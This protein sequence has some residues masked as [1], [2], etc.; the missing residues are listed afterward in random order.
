[1]W[2]NHCVS[3][4]LH[5]RY[6]RR[7]HTPSHISHE[8]HIRYHT[9]FHGRVDA[10]LLHSAR[11]RRRGVNKIITCCLLVLW[12]TD[13]SWR[14]QMWQNHYI[15]HELHIRYHMASHRRVDAILLHPARWRRRGVTI[16]LSLVT[17][18]GSSVSSLFAWYFLIL[19]LC[20]VIVCHYTR[21]CPAF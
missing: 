12:F 9:P 5:I 15:S 6:S 14:G 11:Q 3:L 7:F 17:L 10:V 18:A 1:M 13:F 20:E 19:P 4:E 16:K 2:Q 21:R 8:L